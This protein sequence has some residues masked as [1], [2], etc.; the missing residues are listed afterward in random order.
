M[1]AAK[2]IVAF[3]IA[4]TLGGCFERTPKLTEAD[5]KIFEAVI[6]LFTGLE[7]NLDETDGK[8]MPWQRAV[9][10]RSIEYWRVGKNGISMSSDQ[11]FTK[12]TSESRYVRYVWRL[13]SP[14][15]CIFKFEEVDEFSKGDST[16]DFSAYSSSNDLNALTFNLANAHT[17]VLETEDFGKPYIRLLGPRVVCN[18]YNAFCENVWNSVST[19]L[20]LGRFSGSQEERRQKA[21]NIVKAACPGKDF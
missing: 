16:K 7:D 19:G 4:V 8:G 13:T 20:S 14:A 3:G 12:K 2:W 10:G 6:Y 18:N 11:E 21:F 9:K 15:P 1:R 17:F 5:E